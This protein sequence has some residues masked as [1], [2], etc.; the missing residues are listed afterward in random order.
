MHNRLRNPFGYR[1]P[2]SP[3][4]RVGVMAVVVAAHTS[5]LWELGELRAR[6]ISVGDVRT[7]EMRFEIEPPHP[8]ALGVQLAMAQDVERL[9]DPPRPDPPQLQ[10]M[11]APAP[12]PL[13]PGDLPTPLP[14]L[15]QPRPPAPPRQS[16]PV[17]AASVAP[18]EPPPIE[19]PSERT[20]GHRVVKQADLVTLKPVRLVYPPE[21]LQ[22]GHSGGAAL[23]VLID[24][25]G[26]PSTV[27]VTVTSSY[28]ELDA[29]A[30]RAIRAARFK[31]YVANGEPEAVWVDFLAF[32]FLKKE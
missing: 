15:M 9:L 23:R 20:T 14:Q 29:E 18:S 19:L 32:F 10:A 6:K 8:P 5:F 26:R 24:V 3:V 12:P 2:P 30:I 7:I 28:A 25:T 31:P 21:A 22:A 17:Q 1:E 4:P 13:A 27:R 11:A 16:A